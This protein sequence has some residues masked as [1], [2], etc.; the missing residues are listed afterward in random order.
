MIFKSFD[1]THWFWIVG[2][3]ESRAWSSAAKAYVEEWP[4]DRQTRILNEAELTD[5]LRAHGLPGP[6]VT[7]ADVKAEAQR[8]IVA[9]TGATDLQSCL[10]K[11]LNA[12]MRANELNDKRLTGGELTIE[13]A[14]EAAALRGLA[15]SIKSV[16]AASNEIEAMSPI[17]ADYADDSRWVAAA[18]L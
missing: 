8:R 10:I 7:V 6:L 4:A 18:Q 11:Q 15:E 3:D 2:S 12:N 14:A 9:L 17:P 13:E 5:V 16:R 1:A